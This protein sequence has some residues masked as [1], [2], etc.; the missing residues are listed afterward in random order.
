M[1]EGIARSASRSAVPPDLPRRRRPGARAPY[2]APGGGGEVAEGMVLAIEPGCY[3]EVGGA[4]VEDNFLIT[5]DRPEKL[6][7]RSRRNRAGNEL[8]RRDYTRVRRIDVEG[9]HGNPESQALDPQ[10]RMTVGLYDTT[11]RDG[12]QTIGVVPTPE[13]KLEIAERSTGGDRPDR[14]GLP[15]RSDDDS[16]GRVIAAAGLPAEV[17]ASRARCR[18]TS[19][20]SSSSAS[21]VCDR[22]PISDASST[23]S[24]SRARRC[25]SGSAAAVSFAAAH[26]IASRSSAFILPA[27]NSILRRAYAVAVEAGEREVVV[28]DTLGIRHRRPRVPR[29]PTADSARPRYPCSLARH[30]DF[31]LATAAAVAAAQ[32]GATRSRER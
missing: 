10:P 25:S 2:A 18:P 17:G 13:E 19:R 28:V 21:G 31:G 15:A 8:L 29:R 1:R 3:W 22:E 11:L 24:A 27:P 32:A 4:C 5:A 12:E 23:R 7:A 26:G 9:L 14:G 20:R 30:H 6:S 16:R